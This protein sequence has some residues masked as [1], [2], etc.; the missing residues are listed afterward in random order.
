MPNNAVISLVPGTLPTGYCFTTLQQL[1]NDIISLASGYLPGKYNTFNYGS[2]TPAAEDRDKPWFRL[3]V[4]GT[5][6]KWYVY[7]NGAWSTPYRV[8]ATSSERML[9]VGSLVDLQS[10]DGGSP[11]AV[12]ATTGPFWEEDTDFAGRSPMHPGAIPASNPAK[13]L[14]V[15]EDFGEGAHLQDTQ[16]VGPHPH[17]FSHPRVEG[18][19]S[20]DITGG[21]VIAGDVGT[22]PQTGTASALSN[23]YTTVQKAMPVIHPVRGIFICKRTIRTLWT[24]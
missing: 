14:A 16:E 23:T 24:V 11:G 22:G 10:Y 13:T 15:G 8:P 5:P 21:D 9:W 6:D 1:N 19:G 17:P 3:F 4:D 7:F 18:S 20:T 12:T 2:D